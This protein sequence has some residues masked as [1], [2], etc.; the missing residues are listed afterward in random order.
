M[1][2]LLAAVSH[3]DPR[4]LSIIGNESLNLLLVFTIIYIVG[5]FYIKNHYYKILIASAYF[6]SFVVLTFLYGIGR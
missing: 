1:Q 5:I 6:V 4:P 2:Y 3:G